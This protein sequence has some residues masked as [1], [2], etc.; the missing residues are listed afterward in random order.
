MRASTH[1]QDTHDIYAQDI[2]EKTGAFRRVVIY[3][4]PAAVEV[5]LNL[6]FLAHLIAFLLDLAI[7]KNVLTPHVLSNKGA[8]C[9]STAPLLNTPA[10]FVGD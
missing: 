10:F 8:V 4:S 3:L 7:N 9:A 1:T 2:S 5:E 6:A